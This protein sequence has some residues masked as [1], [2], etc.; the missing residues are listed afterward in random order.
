MGAFID[1]FD[2]LS[3]TMVFGYVIVGDSF[4][5]SQNAR[6][7]TALREVVV[8]KTQKTI[9]G[10]LDSG[11]VYRDELAAL[12]VLQNLRDPK[13]ASYFGEKDSVDLDSFAARKLSAK[14]LSHSVSAD[15]I[16]E[17]F[18]RAEL[19]AD[20]NETS[21]LDQRELVAL[22]NVIGEN[23]YKAYRGGTG[24]E[25]VRYALTEVSAGKRR[26]L[27]LR[28]TGQ[29][30]DMAVLY[31][32]PYHLSSVCTDVRGPLNL[33]RERIKE[34]GD[35]SKIQLS[36]LVISWGEP[37]TEKELAILVARTAVRKL[38]PKGRAALAGIPAAA[39]LI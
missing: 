8:D 21:H 10:H 17:L 31:A 15:E 13:K 33:L 4:I 32:A 18:A 23:P 11:C 5:G 26:L 9:F 20:L 12:E 2:D 30:D 1:G 14:V 3:E 38:S 24:E 29:N 19:D 36:K 37:I 27:G 39:C 22:F 6:W 35:T 25:N 16:D 28:F 34:G 7:P